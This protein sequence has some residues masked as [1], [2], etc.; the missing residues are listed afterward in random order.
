MPQVDIP[1]QPELLPVKWIH[2][3][4]NTLHTL[5]TAE[6]K[7]LAINISRLEAHNILLEEIIKTITKPPNN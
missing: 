5:T 6:A 1:A 4:D 3:K 2:N 7:N